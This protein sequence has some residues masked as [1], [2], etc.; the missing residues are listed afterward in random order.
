V[1]NREYIDK[2]YNLARLI[3]MMEIELLSSDIRAKISDSNLSLSEKLQY[4]VSLCSELK[5]DDRKSSLAYELLNL[6]PDEESIRL[7]YDALL[8]QRGQEEANKLILA[9]DRLNYFKQLE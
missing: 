9:Y 1:R 6:S 2:F 3:V 7:A 8:K 5:G 4:Y